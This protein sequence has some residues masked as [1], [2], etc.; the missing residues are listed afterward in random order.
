[1][2]V[3]LDGEEG[4]QGCQAPSTS[5]QK[6]SPRRGHPLLVAQRGNDEEI[7]VQADHAQI[8][9]GRTAA[10]DVEAKPNWA[11][12]GPQHPGAAQHVEHGWGHDHQRHHQVREEQRDQE[13]VGGAAQRAMGKHQSDEQEVST[14][15]Q[16]DDGRQHEGQQPWTAACDVP[17]GGGWRAAIEAAQRAGQMSV[18]H[19]GG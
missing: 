11:K 2:P 1:M 13:A 19:G 14:D 18:G 7:T 12:G 10:H 17:V 8:E 3:H 15:C 5:N 4:G 16:E 6:Q 9:D